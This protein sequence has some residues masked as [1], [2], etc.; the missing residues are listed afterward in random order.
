L[1]KVRGQT[2]KKIAF[3]M[4]WSFRT[5]S[6]KVQFGAKANFVVLGLEPLAL[7]VGGRTQN[8]L[9]LTCLGAFEVGAQKFQ[10]GPRQFFW[11]SAISGCVEKWPNAK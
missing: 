9:H 2:Q 7:K 5:W 6:L 8:N 1:L 11:H 4:S 3:N 10:Q